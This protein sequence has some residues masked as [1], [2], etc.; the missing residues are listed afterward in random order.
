MLRDRGKDKE[1]WVRQ[2]LGG[3]GGC[4]G[5]RKCR[6]NFVYEEKPIIQFSWNQI[7]CRTESI[8]GIMGEEEFRAISYKDPGEPKRDFW[9]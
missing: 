4:F 2:G 1:L 8:S 6:R 3:D 7:P 5:W 9:T